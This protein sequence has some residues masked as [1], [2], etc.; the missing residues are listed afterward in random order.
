MAVQHDTA[1]DSGHTPCKDGKKNSSQGST[2]TKTLNYTN[3]IN[4]V[5]TMIHNCTLNIF[6]SGADN[7]IHKMESGKLLTQLWD[8]AC[9][10]NVKAIINAMFFFLT[11]IECKYLRR[12]SQKIMIN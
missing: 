4:N 10:T 11:E 12:S 6:I 8:P 5:L 9:K 1:E 7:T 3:E 2:N